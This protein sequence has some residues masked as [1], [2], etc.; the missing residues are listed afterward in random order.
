ML[1]STAVEARLAAYLRLLE[2][3]NSRINLVGR[4]EG[5]GLIQR[6]L[7]DSLAVVPLLPASATRIVDLGAG[8]GFPG[9]VV[10][11][12][13]GIA[14]HLIER[15]QRKCAFL[16]EAR[17]QTDA[18]VEVHQADFSTLPALAADVVLSRATARLPG[19]LDAA[20]R[21]ARKGGTMLFHKSEAQ[22]A[23]I[24]AARA[25]WRFRVQDFAN[26]ADRRGRV[27]R[28]TELRRHHD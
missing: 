1:A 7:L 24:E 18:P 5:A 3:W 26:P 4:G 11:I 13:T 22:T 10:A 19:L 12:A 14:T 20:A 16:R 23:E 15:D 28:I 9:L 27:W 25:G 8:G 21:H 6:H 2:T 17:R